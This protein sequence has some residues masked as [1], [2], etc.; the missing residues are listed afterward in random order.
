VLIV[1]RKLFYGKRSQFVYGLEAEV[2]NVSVGRQVITQRLR[3]HFFFDPSQ[4]T[5]AGYSGTHQGS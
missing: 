2:A 1:S 4:L 3:Q 5:V